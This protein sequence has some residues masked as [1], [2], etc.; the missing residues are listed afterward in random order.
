MMFCSLCGHF[1]TPVDPIRSAWERDS[2]VFGKRFPGPPGEFDCVVVLLSKRFSRC[3]GELVCFAST[4]MLLSCH[5]C[6]TSFKGT[7]WP[8]EGLEGVPIMSLE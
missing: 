4:F 8:G 2:T 6:E 7:G 1:L 3:S 5:V